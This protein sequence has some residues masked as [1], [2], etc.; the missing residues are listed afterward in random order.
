MGRT[1]GIQPTKDGGYKVDK[2]YRKRRIQQ[3]GFHTVDEAE[4]WLIRTIDAL[5][6][7]FVHGLRPQ[8]TF[9]QAATHYVQLYQHKLSLDSDIADLKAVMPYIGHMHLDQIHN[10][11]LKAFVDARKAQG[12]KNKTINHSLAIVRRILNLAAKDWRDEN[13]VTW[14]LTAPM[15]TLLKLTDQRPPR[16]LMW[17]EQ[18]RLI[19]L[20][21]DHLAPMALFAL[22][23]GCRDDVVCNLQWEWEIPIAQLDVS[24][25]IVPP[26][27]V[28]G[29]EDHKR[30]RVLVLNSVAQKVIE[31]R[32]G[33]HPTHVFTYRGHPIT[34]MLNT[35]WENARKKAGVADVNVHDLRHTVGLRLRESKVAET[36]IS[37]ILWHSNKSMTEHYSMAQIVEVYEALEL[38]KDES[39]RW[40]ISLEALKREKAFR[41]V[42]QKS[43]TLD[44]EKKTG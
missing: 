4:S 17:A 19:P 31:Q 20:L 3:G 34:G 21:P 32:R 38:I 35:A 18:R 6:M 1:S 44:L 5:R 7:Q 23:T 27:H 40:N 14:L 10:G 39:N 30:E 22:N 41:K 36:T 25:F 37:A 42:T 26:M 8:R 29:D 2:I 43:L 24:V 13:G 15:I 12:R 33:M 11:T 28:K 16:P 9:E